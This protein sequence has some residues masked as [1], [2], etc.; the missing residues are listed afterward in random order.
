MSL[1]TNV[2]GLSPVTREIKELWTNVTGLSPVTRQITEVWAN[3]GTTPR[4][5]YSTW[6]APNVVWTSS[7][8]RTMTD[9]P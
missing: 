8:D 6:K 2:T 7:G 3:D 9:T 5:I 1:W 4:Q